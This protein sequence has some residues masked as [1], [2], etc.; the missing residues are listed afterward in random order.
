LGGGSDG[1]NLAWCCPSCNLHKSNKVEAIDPV[2]GDI[3]AFFDPRQDEWPKHFDWVGY[4]LVGQTSVGRATAHALQLNQPRR[5]L[6][7]QAEAIF[8]LFPP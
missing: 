7:R 6:I 2:S 1:A 5:I 8:D 4:Q 3:V